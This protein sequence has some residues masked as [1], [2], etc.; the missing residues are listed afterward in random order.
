M[1]YPI[2]QDAGVVKRHL[3]IGKFCQQ[4]DKRKIALFIGM[5]D[6]MIEIAHRLMVMYAETKI[7]QNIL[8]YAEMYIFFRM[9]IYIRYQRVKVVH[10]LAKVKIQ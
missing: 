7:N 6:Y 10:C 3:D 8:K 4:F 1:L 2:P 5:L 9:F